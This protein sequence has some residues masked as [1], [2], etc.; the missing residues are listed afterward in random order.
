[1]VM[2]ATYHTDAV[3]FLS[4]HYNH[5]TS[6]SHLSR[7]YKTTVQLRSGNYDLATKAF[8]TLR[9]HLTKRHAEF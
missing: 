5:S 4:P 6:S 1:M 3:A 2:K 7:L 9:S 8:Q